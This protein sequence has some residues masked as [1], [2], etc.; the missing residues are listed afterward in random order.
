M[1][2]GGGAGRHHGRGFVYVMYDSETNHVK[3]G[4]SRKLKRRLKDIKRNRPETICVGKVKANEMN[5]AET[6]AQHAV[7]LHLGMQK[8]TNNATDWYHL[9]TNVTVEDVLDRVRQAV[10]YHNRQS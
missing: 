9:P 1:I 2:T 7:E 3:I 6:A 8:I 10:Y 5:R 4:Y